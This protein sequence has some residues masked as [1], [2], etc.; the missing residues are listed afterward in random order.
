M[1]PIT[2]VI[3]L[4][5]GLGLICAIATFV[6]E[7]L[8]PRRPAPPATPEPAPDPPAMTYRLPPPDPSEVDAARRGALL[9]QKAAAA[10]QL[11]M[12]TA[13]LAAARRRAEAEAALHQTLDQRPDG[14]SDVPEAFRRAFGRQVD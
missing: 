11:D 4:F 10:A 7:V 1:P 13:V 9:L 6:G 5:V 8:A 12:D 3:Y 2:Y 14:T